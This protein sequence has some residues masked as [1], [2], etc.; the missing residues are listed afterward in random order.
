MILNRPFRV[1]SFYTRGSDY[2]RHAKN[3]ESSCRSLE[4]P[5]SISSIEPQDTWVRNCAQKGPFLLRELQK[6]TSPLVWLDA[7]AE[8]RQYPRL[9]DSPDFEFG[10]YWKGEKLLSGTLYL[11]PTLETIRIVRLWAELC[12]TIPDIWDQVHLQQVVRDNGS[13]LRIGQLPKA[14]CKIVDQSLPNDETPVIVHYQ[15]SRR[16]K[17]VANQLRRQ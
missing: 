16:L 6:A 7:D 2:R 10:A 4:I 17:R 15:A 5:C 14:Y 1:V 3:L 9:F 13:D 11:A 8:V 12:R